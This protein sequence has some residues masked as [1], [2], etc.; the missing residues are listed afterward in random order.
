M[1][2]R[3]LIQGWNAFFFTPESPTPIALYRILYGLLMIVNLLI[4]RPEWLTWYGPRG[5]MTLE[6]MRKVVGGPRINFFELLPPTDFAANVFFWAFLLLA[7][8]LTAG[9]MTRFASVAVYTCLLSLHLRNGYIMNGGDGFLRATGFF[10]M[11]APAGAAFSVDRLLRI[12]AGREGGTLPLHSPWALRLIQIQIAVVYF[13]TFY[14]KTLGTTWINGTAIYYVLRLEEDH[15]FPVPF[16]HSLLLI[17]LAT[18]LTLLIEFSMAVLVWSR[19][20]RYPVLL[21]ALCLH[22]GIEYSMNIPLFEWIMIAGLVT[23][24]YPEDLA[25]AWAWVRNW[26]DRSLARERWDGDEKQLQNLIAAPIRRILS[27]KILAR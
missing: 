27:R 19:E 3:R 23:F 16:V 13:S 26:I 21:A 9:F 11:F 17:K 8:F 4:L 10:L 15:R 22:L 14:W 5:F 2:W 12:R 20:L 7:V 6:T 18:W 1:I 25:R 24:I